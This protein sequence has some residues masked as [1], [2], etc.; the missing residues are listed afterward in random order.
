MYDSST[1][2]LFIHIP[3]TAGQSVITY[4]LDLHNLSW[5]K[6]HLLHVK[7]NEDMSQGSPQVTHFTINEYKTYLP[8]QK[9]FEGFDGLKIFTIVRNPYSRFWSEYNFFWKG[10]ITWDTFCTEKFQE[11]IKDNF[12]SG[13]DAKRHIKPQHEFFNEGTRILRFENLQDDFANMCNVFK[14]RH[15]PLK[16]VNSSKSVDYREVYDSEKLE[17]VYSR[18][19][20]D[21]ELLSYPKAID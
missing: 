19:K 18:Y 17:F 6:R 12:D 11:S 1:K 2:T 4:F 15:R 5:E 10:I 3:K 20:K 8:K 21:F 9:S 7:R 13:R 16:L 14:L